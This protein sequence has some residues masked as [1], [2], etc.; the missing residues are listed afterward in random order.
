MMTEEELLSLAEEQGGEVDTT[1]QFCNQ[2]YRFDTADI[3]ALFKNDGQLN[4]TN[5]VH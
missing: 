5:A 1:C 2:I 3:Q 4:E